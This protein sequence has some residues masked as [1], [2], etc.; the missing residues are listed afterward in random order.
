MSNEEWHVKPTAEWESYLDYVHEL[1]GSN[2]GVLGFSYRRLLDD[3]S[4]LKVVTGTVLNHTYML[5]EQPL[6]TTQ[7][8]LDSL[9]QAE[10]KFPLD[11][12]LEYDYKTLRSQL[13]LTY[14]NKFSN[15]FRIKVGASLTAN[16]YWLN[17]NE[18]TAKG[19]ESFLDNISGNTFLV[20]AYAQGSY[21]PVNKL[22]INFGF[23]AMYL[24]LNNTFS[25]EPRVSLQYK[26][27]KKTTFALAYGIH[28]KELGIG[29]Y[30]L[31]VQDNLGNRSQPNKDLKI[32]KAHH[33]V[34]SFQQVIGYGFRANVE[35]YYQYHFDNPTG[36]GHQ[37]G[38]WLFNER[39]NY[40]NQALVSEGQGQNYGVD[41]TVEKAFGNNFFMMVT[42][43][44]YWTQFKSRGDTEWRRARTDKR[45]GTTIMGGYEFTFKKGGVLQLGV[46]SFISGGLRYTAGDLEASKVAG[47]F[48]PDNDKIYGETSGTYFRLD[49]RIAYR[50]DHKKLSYTISLD[51]QN[52]TN[53]KNVRYKIYDRINNQLINRAQSG[54]LPVLA[55]QL[56]F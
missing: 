30:L 53:T 33:A 11:T 37:S 6:F 42:G 4:Y 32:A 38:Y 39:D 46:K 17:Y 10:Y 3:K 15:Q 51:V 35:A 22:T 34:F 28:G 14:S 48:V 45:W 2:M 29:T 18:I 40:G 13:H 41:L 5:Q 43:S 52:C 9:E 56:D 21:R 19:R 16:T 44:L 49:A 26:P 50:K 47:V 8:N 27:F 7:S 24:A 12:I 54:L 1:S 55:F 25:V 23:H 20:Q 36:V 31:Q